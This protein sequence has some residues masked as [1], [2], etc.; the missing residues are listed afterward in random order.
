LRLYGLTGNGAGRILCRL[1][2]KL[3]GKEFEADKVPERME[4][5]FFVRIFRM[6]DNGF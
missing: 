2:T 1:V 4:A 6:A 3:K 5:G